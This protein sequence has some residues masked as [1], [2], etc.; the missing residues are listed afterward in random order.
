MRMYNNVCTCISVIFLIAV[1]L[2]TSDGLDEAVQCLSGKSILI[3]SHNT[4]RMHKYQSPLLWHNYIHVH[5][6]ARKLLMHTLHLTGELRSKSI[7]W[8]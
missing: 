4:S 2:C 3:E 7:L 8:Q 6:Y 5:A 1:Q